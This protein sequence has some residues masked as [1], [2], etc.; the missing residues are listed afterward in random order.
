MSEK[1]SSS[2][3]LLKQS[4]PQGQRPILKAE[5][6]SSSEALREDEVRSSSEALLKAESRSSRAKKD[7]A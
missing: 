4:A 7:S 3:A 1:K 6:R 5:S 2:E